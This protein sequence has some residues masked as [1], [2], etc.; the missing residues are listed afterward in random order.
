MGIDQEIARRVCNECGGLPLALKVV[1]QA[2][3]GITQSNEW[4]L[5]VKRLQNDVTNSLYGKLRLSYDA[6]ADLAGYGISLQLCFLC[7]AA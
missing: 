7:L 4:E 6:M 5:A 3:A 1:G 2:M